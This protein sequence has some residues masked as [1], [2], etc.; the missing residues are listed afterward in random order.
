M[1][2][3]APFISEDALFVEGGGGVYGG[4]GGYGGGQ[5][6][7]RERTPYPTASK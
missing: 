3:A 7:V 6:V 5:Q 4:G 2:G 1:E